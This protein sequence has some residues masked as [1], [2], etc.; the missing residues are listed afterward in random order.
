MKLVLAFGLVLLGA[1]L[2]SE[3][4]RTTILST[5]VMFLAAGL[6]LGRFGLDWAG[7]EPSN[8]II[9]EFAELALFSTLLVDGS[10]MPLRDVLEAWQLPGRALLLGLPLTL[11]ATALAARWVVGLG[12][13]ESFLLGA[14]LS[15][16]DP[17]FAAAILE[18]ESV[19]LR[20]RRLLTI[21]SGLNDGLALP[22]VM[23]LLAASSG[24]HASA[25]MPIVDAAVGLLFGIAVSVVFLWLEARPMFQASESYWPLAGVAIG[26]TVLGSARM[27]G[28]NEFLAAFAAGIAFGSANPIAARA[29]HPVGLPISELWKLAA[30]LVFG[31][32]VSRELFL[33]IGWRGWAFALIA[34]LAT[35][36]IGLLLAFL[37]GGL[38]RLEWL[39]A[40][41]FG[42]KGFASILYGLLVV[43][44]GLPQGLQIFRLVAV[45]TILSIVAHSSTDVVVA[46]VFRKAEQSQGRTD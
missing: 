28:I 38:T 34:L 1:V 27:L 11:L 15:P 41:W 22:V 5:S 39:A 42:P 26:A 13:T 21:E 45:T 32:V 35:R 29:F 3:R 7:V 2:V 9:S 17:V 23:V 46:R 8:P 6:L 4:A 19:P 14:I 10:R 36:P 25:W 12:W 20:L 43:Q 33:D 24:T 18:H 37:G 31:A 40:A 44:S 30:L 16:T